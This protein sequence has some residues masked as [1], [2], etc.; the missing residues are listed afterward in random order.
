[1]RRGGRE[2]HAHTGRLCKSLPTGLEA[3]GAREPR[4]GGRKAGVSKGMDSFLD[5]PREASPTDPLILAQENG[6]EASDPQNCKTTHLC[7]LKPP[8]RWPST[9]VAIENE[10][11]CKS[12]QIIFPPKGA[13]A[14][15]LTS[16]LEK[17]ELLGVPASTG[18]QSSDTD[19][20]RDRKSLYMQ[21]MGSGGSPPGLKCW[22]GPLLAM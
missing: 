3:E 5:L 17:P 11:V 13:S 15:H 20:H 7:C 14:K 18:A 1:M 16:S 8:N 12:N 9:A 19:W 21:S 2:E 4:N 10:H 6:R 22:L